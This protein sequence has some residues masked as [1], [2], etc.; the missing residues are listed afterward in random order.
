MNPI[1]IL[2]IINNLSY[3]GTERQLAE[4]I[5]RLDRSR[6]R[7]HLCTLNT[8]EKLYDELDVPKLFLDQAKFGHRSMLRRAFALS[9]YVR[10]NRI[11]IIQTFFQDPFLLA[12][13]IRPFHRVRMVG[14]FRDL[15]FWRKPSE[16]WK[17]RL[18]YPFFAG[19]IANSYAVKEHFVRTDGI[20]GNRIE[21]IYNG[22]DCA[23]IPETVPGGGA[24]DLPVVGI[25]ANLNRRVKR[26]EDFI[27]AAAMVKEKVPGVRFVI[28]GDGPLRGELESLAGSLGLNGSI[29]FTGRISN[30]LDEV[31]Q[32]TIGVLTSETEGFSN[33]IIEYMAFG[34]PVIATDTGGNPELVTEGENG[35]LVPV[36][37]CVVMAER[38]V[39]LL[40]DRACRAW[41]GETNWE[42]IRNKFSW[43]AALERQCDYYEKLVAG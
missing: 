3:G 10:E 7:P 36:G 22:F 28:V 23:S 11:R 27:Q 41:I 5:R 24:G 35:Y 33:A 34:I 32:F 25:V 17:M 18:T 14:T 40:T 19:F 30:P 26:V 9:R 37:D 38:I 29:R 1:N 20:D 12:A 31:R 16:T 42:K 4:L 39:N 43:S 6:F 15:G 2:Y 21:V 13:M 8:S